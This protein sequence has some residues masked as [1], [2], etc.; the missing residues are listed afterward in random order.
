MDQVP[1][2]KP[3][4]DACVLD[5]TFCQPC[6]QDGETRPVEDYCTICKECMC[7]I[8]T[9][10]HKKQKTTKSHTFLDKSNLPSTMRDLTTS[11][12]ESKHYCD[13]HPGEYIKYFCPTHQTLN[14]GHCSVLNHQSC[15]QQIISEIGKA[16][17]E[18]K[19]YEAIKQDIVEL[20]RETEACVS[21]VK[22]NIKLVEGF[23]EY[24]I[25]EI[26]NYRDKINKYFDERENA[27]LMII[28]QMQSIDETFLGSLKSECDN[29]K[30]E[31]NAIKA[32][33]VARENNTCQLFVEAHVTK[34]VLKGLQLTLADIN[35][36][37]SIHQYR[38]RKDPTTEKLLGSKTGFGSIEDL[39][40]AN[41]LGL[42]EHTPSA[43]VDNQAA[44]TTK[45]FSANTVTTLYLNPSG[46][47]ISAKPKHEKRNIVYDLTSLTF[48]PARDIL[49]KSPY[50][51]K[52][53][54]LTSLLLLPGD[55]LLLADNY[56]DTVKLVDLNTSSLVAEVSVTKELWDM[57]LLL[58]DWVAI[59]S[60]GSIQFLDTRGQLSL[61]HTI[62][63]DGECHGVG[64]DDNNLFVSYCGGKVEKMDM[65][66]KVLKKVSK[67]WFSNS[68]FKK[69]FYLTV[70][71][72]GPSKA[73]YV[74]DHGT[75]TITKLDMNLNILQTFQ[76]PA[77]RD[78]RGITV[79][80]NQLII[81]CRE[82][83]HI[84][85]LDLLSGHMTQLLGKKDGIASPRNVTY[86][87]QH[88]KMYV[89][90]DTYVNADYVK[91][92]KA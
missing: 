24:A 86:S 40:N 63:V 51:S 16:F 65:E 61:R 57:C 2:R 85:C 1:G 45:T 17:K 11:E 84:K 90:I 28:T 82:S 48:T 9:N 74:S 18:G 20:L 37:N 58:W 70:V 62:K 14:C 4:A 87:Q 56:N 89:T 60:T 30:M 76:D 77:L 31:V 53:G 15:K 7:S 91:V 5:V 78:P 73:I 35:M 54:W 80:G 34:D 44:E 27:L 19:G 10:V 75:D 36:K 41:A 79:V 43:V 55:R 42:D 67:G 8:C 13:I 25:T 38:F 3:Q 39:A 22:E 47:Q 21:E 59:C 52:D 72:E 88:N 12:E 46:A 92:Y 49:V 71:S 81:C 29:L 68:P 83:S 64:Y 23:G 69:P 32:K 6:F 26:R 50:D 66:G 33:L